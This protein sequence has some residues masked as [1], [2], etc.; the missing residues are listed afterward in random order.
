ML[1][2]LPAICPAT[3][4]NQY[5][6]RTA[7]TDP[8]SQAG[9][10]GHPA[11][12]PQR[13]DQH[14]TMRPAEHAGMRTALQNTA[15]LHRHSPDT[16]TAA[17]DTAPKTS[18]S[19]YEAAPDCELLVPHPPAVVGTVQ[20][21]NAPQPEQAPLADP[22][23]QSQGRQALQRS[24]DFANDPAPASTAAPDRVTHPPVAPHPAHPPRVEASAA[25][26][27]CGDGDEKPDYRVNAVQRYSKGRD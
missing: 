27:S 18:P 19:A 3:T 20:P 9:S 8:A 22:A 10:V 17:A 14:A 24:M 16:H 21:S 7:H 5:L 12:R 2:P 6:Q 11:P 13:P 23:S 1:E 25:A 26:T 4:S 15:T